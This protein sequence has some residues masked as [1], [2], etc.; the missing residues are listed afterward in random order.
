MLLAEVVTSEQNVGG[1]G[2]LPMDLK[3]AYGHLKL[4]DELL[5]QYNFTTLGG[6][7]T[8]LYQPKPGFHGLTLISRKFNELWIAFSLRSKTFPLLEMMY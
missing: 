2:F 6:N 4:C 5:A 7:A 8:E 1:V 3:Y